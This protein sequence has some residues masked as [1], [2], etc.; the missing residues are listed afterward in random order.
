MAMV[1]V[2]LM[3]YQVRGRG[4]YRPRAERGTN[5]TRTF[6]RPKRS[7]EIRELILGSLQF[8]DCFFWTMGLASATGSA[9]EARRGRENR[10]ER[11]QAKQAGEK[12]P[13]VS[14]DNWLALILLVVTI[15]CFT[16]LG[17]AWTYWWSR[18]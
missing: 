9:V 3:K 18:E 11:R 14:R 6:F 12:P 2:G 4:W 1:W 10:I 17:A 15:A 5:V 16:I 7:M 8:C 13:P